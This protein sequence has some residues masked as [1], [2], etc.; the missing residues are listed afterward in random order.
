MR[1]ALAP[2]LAT[3]LLFVFSSL[4]AAAGPYDIGVHLQP[5]P[6]VAGVLNTVTLQVSHI[7]APVSNLTVVVKPEMPEMPGMPSQA[8][9]ASP[10]A[11]PGQY[12]AQV[13]LAMEGNWNLRVG[14]VGPLGRE[15]EDFTLA[16][17]APGTTGWATHS[18]SGPWIVGAFSTLIVAA[19]VAALVAKRRPVKTTGKAR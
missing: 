14:V 2:T 9:Q 11:T 1:K 13:P 5:Q 19:I 15:E 17:V 16:V 7:G 12:Q 4:A 18:G 10:L 3:M 6:P 8:V